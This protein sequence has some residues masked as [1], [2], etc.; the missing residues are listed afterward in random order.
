MLKA[1]TTH[2]VTYSR[3]SESGTDPYGNPADTWTDDAAT[4][5]VIL[6]QTEAVEV[7]TDRDVQTSDWLLV[8]PNPD[9]GLSGRDRVNAGGAVF[10]VV[11]PPEVVKTPRGAHHLEA[12]L[13]HV[14]PS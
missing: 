6:Q 10:E 11:G 7:T 1:L 8:D 2:T 12:R 9:A 3:W 13:V 4:A 14:D 5:D